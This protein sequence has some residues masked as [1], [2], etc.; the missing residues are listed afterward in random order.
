M[1]NF[2]SS[3]Q[4]APNVTTTTPANNSNGTNNNSKPRRRRRRRGKNARRGGGKVEPLANVS[5]SDNGATKKTHDEPMTKGD[6]YFAMDCEMVGV[7]PDGTEN[8]VGRVTIVNWCNNIILDTYVKVP[9]PVTDYRTYVSGI[10]PEDLCDDGEGNGNGNNSENL[11]SF[12][13]VRNLVRDILHG[14]ILIG[15]GLQ[16][17]LDALQMTH[18]ECDIR[19]TAKFERFMRK[20]STD[21]QQNRPHLS[22]VGAGLGS[23]NGKN[24][25]FVYLPRK[26]RDL[27]WDVLNR[28]I[29]NPNKPHC[30]I[31]DAT[32]A[33]DL[34][35]AVQSEWENS[36]IKLFHKNEE[37]KQKQLLQQRQQQRQQQEQQQQQ[38]IALVN[39]RRRQQQLWQQQQQQQAAA[40]ALENQ[41]RWHIAAAAAAQQSPVMYHHNSMPYGG[42]SNSQYHNNMASYSAGTPT[43]RQ[44]TPRGYTLS[45]SS[46]YPSSNNSIGVQVVSPN[47]NVHNIHNHASFFPN[48]P[49]HQQNASVNRLFHDLQEQEEQAQQQAN[50]STRSSFTMQQQRQSSS[51]FS[52]YRQKSSKQVGL[53][54][55]QPPVQQNNISTSHSKVET[56]TGADGA[57]SSGNRVTSDLDGLNNQQLSL[58]Q[59]KSNSV[60]Q[61]DGSNGKSSSSKNH[62]I[63]EGYQP[64]RY[65][66]SPPNVVVTSTSIIMQQEQQEAAASSSS[67]QQQPPATSSGSSGRSWFSS[68]RFTSSSSKNGRN[69]E[70]DTSQHQE[71]KIDASASGSNDTASLLCDAS[72]QQG[73]N[74]KGEVELEVT[75][76]DEFDSQSP[77]ERDPVA[78]DV[79]T[80]E[81]YEPPR[82]Y[83]SS[84]PN[85]VVEKAEVSTSTSSSSGSW[86]RRSRRSV[87]QLQEPQIVELDLQNL[88][89]KESE[90]FDT[91]RTSL[92]ME[93]LE[94]GS[95]CSAAS[96]SAT[97][98]HGSLVIADDHSTATDKNNELRG[99]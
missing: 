54:Q 8:A 80:N 34:Y 21:S 17:D 9:V 69:Q 86:F 12:Q 41:R 92:A 38:A 24:N 18:P 15:H 95:A 55:Q 22:H 87:R 29:Q 99:I 66:T 26:L 13:E 30:P 28:Q 52:Y 89:V 46:R 59:N 45:P 90:E 10:K 56:R 84:T 31:E 44:A 39:E 47:R 74:E 35:K 11:M 49:T 19:D 64:P 43:P 42:T 16:C 3:S 63:L 57:A 65:Y 32:A 62:V 2:K 23:N 91:S 61:Q 50:G 94:G 48:S 77:E 79:L 58:L 78:V 4:V 71:E 88:K 5:S 40:A 82:Y 53:T 60:L 73:Q 85:V 1:F 27:S 67:Q 93:A 20:I 37:E 81:N 7:G 14:K 33:L 25:E 51:W 97:V 68:Y 75:G 36:L 98:E 70:E 96:T 72:Q 6:I 76:E 83:T